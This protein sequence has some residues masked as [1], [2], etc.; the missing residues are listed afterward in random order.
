MKTLKALCSTRML[1]MIGLGFT[2][3][4]P[5]LITKDI[6]KAWMTET[7]V[8]LG[9][10]GLFSALSMPYTLK[11]IWAPVMDR[12]VPPFLGRRRGW[13]VIAQIGLVI[14]IASVGQFNPAEQL[15]W[16]A[17]MA[18]AVTFFSASQDIALDAFR[19]E[20]L[21]ENELGFGTAVYMNAYRGA[22][23]ASLAV[24]F[25]AAEKFGWEYAHILLALMMLIGII[26]VL[27]SK[28]PKVDAPPPRSLR[29]AIVGPFSE[30]FKRS[31]WLSILGFVL[32]YK[33]G[34]NM[35]S[36]MNVPYILKM[37]FEKTDYLVIVKGIGMVGL[38][39]GMLLGGAIMTRLG[40]YWS[41][42]IFGV[43]Q[44]V[45]TFGFALIDIF[46]K[47]HFLLSGIV[48]F[49]LLSTGL[50][51]TAYAT[52]VALQTNVRFT[53]TQY[54]LLTSL[55]AV[56]GTLAAALTGYMVEYLGWVGFYAACSL[57]ALPGLLIIP[58][59]CKKDA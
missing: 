55:M 58:K 12:F 7:N 4:L 46:G 6:L 10:I 20:Y 32:L 14:T 43:L 23:L 39:A 42:I 33:L 5:F 50:G 53:A 1:T 19:R 38:F 40:L 2:A 11:F 31:G 26:T 25:L 15:K 17:L 52:F 56:P 59:V 22:N 44:M 18:L 29:E 36:A 54:A 24:A 35:A 21:S 28:E 57:V 27:L 16:I 51:A 47:N 8:D 45:S 13:M 48:V 30:F 3:G 41:L 34:D 49:E 37:G 9:T